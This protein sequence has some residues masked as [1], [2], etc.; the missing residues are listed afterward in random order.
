M[1]EGPFTQGAKS[2][3]FFITY[4]SIKN[5]TKKDFLI[6]QK[7]KY[8]IALVNDL[9][10]GKK[11]KWFLETKLNDGKVIKSEFHYFAILN[12]LMINTKR[13]KAV[14]NYNKKG[15]ILDGL[16]W[17]DQYRCAV[18]R[19]G[20]IVWFIP[21][22][23]NSEIHAKVIRDFKLYRDGSITFINQPNALRTDIDLNTIWQAPYIG[24]ISE[25]AKEDY[26]HDFEVLSNG[27]YMILGNEKVNFSNESEKDTIVSET[28]DFCNIIEFDTT[29]QIVWNWRMKDYFPYE[30]LINS[31]L[32]SQSG[33]V[34]PHA[35]SFCV[36]E[37]QNAIYLSF[38]DISRIIKIDK[39]TK[40]IVASYG[41]KLTDDDTIFETD[42]FR[43]QHDIQLI[44]DNDF[45]IFNNNETTKGKTSSVEIIHLPNSKKDSIYSKW[46]FNLK[47]DKHSTGMA[48]R[49]GGVKIL[50]NGNYLICGGSLNRVIEISP[51][52]KLL[53][54][55]AF[56]QIDTSGYINDKFALYRVNFSP[57]LYPNY[58]R[59]Y[60][61]SKNEITICN[62]GFE[63][64]YFLIQLIEKN[65]SVFFSMET[66]VVK[67][68]QEITLRLPFDNLDEFKIIVISKNTGKS[69]STSSKM[70]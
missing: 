66:A 8:P 56:K 67:S 24:T 14:Q 42:L 48:H 53:W 63:N 12:S 4:D 44:K 47:C 30:Y 28:V 39:K 57:S 22:E 52:K 1:F 9:P 69:K 3:T 25:A 49:M 37:K 13:F 34:N 60:L 31:K 58:F 40:K 15:K 36:D 68:N 19:S 43:L 10:L 41:L 6:K 46:Q 16:I 61:I 18:N 27:N 2:F 65:G 50:P 62:K 11:Y 33:I 7:E 29:G 45:L 32:E 26:H 21:G 55:F 70:N 5:P 54:D 20:K 51:K 35:N 38:R 23:K 17:C 59:P 64:D